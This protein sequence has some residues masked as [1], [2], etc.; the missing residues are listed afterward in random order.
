M[1]AQVVA[2]QVRAD[3][4]LEEDERKANHG[5]EQYHRD[6]G[7]EDVRDDQ[8]I[9]QPPEKASANPKNQPDKKVGQRHKAQKT[10]ERRS[11]DRQAEMNCSPHHGVEH[12]HGESDAVG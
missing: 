10:K 11:R 12:E 6:N 7:H 5:Q 4:K 1:L 3:L 2:Q 8:T 9:A